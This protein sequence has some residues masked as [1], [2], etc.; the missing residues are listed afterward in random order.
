MMYHGK[1]L[2]TNNLL[3]NLYNCSYLVLLLFFSSQYFW[4]ESC[5]LRFTE[6]VTQSK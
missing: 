5:N 3:V 4:L 6:K 2:I 1:R